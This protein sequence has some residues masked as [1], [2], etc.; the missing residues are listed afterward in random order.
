MT[1]AHQLSDDDS[2]HLTVKLTLIDVSSN[3]DQSTDVELLLNEAL[4]LGCARPPGGQ[5]MIRP[6]SE[7][8]VTNVNLGHD[9]CA[10]HAYA[11][12]NTR[13]TT[14]RER[15]T[16]SVMKF[17]KPRDR[18]LALGSL[19]LKSRAYHQQALF[20][21][22]ADRPETSTG[23]GTVGTSSP[24]SL[25]L[26]ELPRT[27]YGKPY[28]S[29]SCERAD[30]KVDEGSSHA[31]VQHT[32]SISHQFPFVGLAQ[33]FQ[34]KTQHQ[35]RSLHVGF[36][37]AMYEDPNPKL[38][39]TTCDFLE[40]FKD[41]FTSSEWGC[42]VDSSAAWF[43][44]RRKSDEDR[45]REF[46]LRWAVKEAY[47]KALGLGLGHDFGKFEIVFDCCEDEDGIG[48]LIEAVETFASIGGGE[49]DANDAF[50]GRRLETLGR[51]RY[52][53]KEANVGA[54]GTWHFTFL[55]LKHPKDGSLG[56]NNSTG[57]ACVCI[58]P[59]EEGMVGYVRDGIVKHEIMAL[60]DAIHWHKRK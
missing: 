22:N 10:I 12:N 11:E 51:I 55:E 43:G 1:S 52:I 40:V 7:S 57:C 27:K 53:E 48:G 56:G 13:S 32:I 24:S 9:E 30:F 18:Y 21:E 50:V 37:I 39:A 44:R 49:T 54:H 16:K 3:S 36:D 58:G 45:R 46:Y 42:I 38:Y 4:D 20:E 28:I 29:R 8:P 17:V 35:N 33:L 15:I 5:T 34:L 2:A 6:S 19:L 47:T 41:S 60:E 14:T 26:V 31:N 59:L 23:E 25:A